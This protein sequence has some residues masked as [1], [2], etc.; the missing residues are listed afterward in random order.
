MSKFT[1]EIELGNDA[2]MNATQLAK[3]LEKVSFRVMKVQYNLEEEYVRGIMDENGNTVGSW[4]I[5]Q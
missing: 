1:L 3:A 4:K 5:S 2:L